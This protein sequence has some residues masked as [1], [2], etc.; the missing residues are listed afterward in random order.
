M[1]KK[2]F[3]TIV[4][5]GCT[6]I[7]AAFIILRYEGFFA[8]L[9]L[10]LNTIRPVILGLIIAFIINKPLYKVDKW[11]KKLYRKRGWTIGEKP[12]KTAI[13]SVYL[14]AV[15]ILGGIICIVVPQLINNVIVLSDNFDTYY[16]NFENIIKTLSGYLEVDWLQ[17]F[18]LMEQLSK[19]AEYIPDIIVKTFNFTADI[20]T[21]V[22][23]FAIGLVLSVYIVSDKAHLKRQA[24][25]VLKKLLKENIYKKT[26]HYLKVAENSFSN[27]ISGQMT[28]A[29]ILGVLCFI[30]MNI[31]GF[32]YS[33][34]ISVVI[35]ITNI[36]P[37]AGP[38]LGTIPCAF[39]LLL[40]NPTQA[41]WFIVFIIILQQLESNLI[42][43]RVVGT[44]VGLPAMWVL[45]A[46]IIGGGL[47][48]VI[49]M[50]IGIPL[51]SVVY[52][53]FR[54]QDTN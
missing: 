11:Y 18:N 34:L 21:A 32:E 44:S 4:A 9:K 49:G 23:D 19:L 28:E 2:L 7:I 51:M 45:I 41:L 24:D 35:G 50:I 38:I 20:V 53:I 30:G 3:K 25:V 43:P 13:L 1:D 14:V 47:Y 22:I 8:V 37:I 39:I 33:L 10:L 26:V 40:A 6:L 54:E 5:S 31:F 15:I 36:I 42:Y 12:L 46:V 29:L 27:F 17:Q 52:G 48:G 16:N